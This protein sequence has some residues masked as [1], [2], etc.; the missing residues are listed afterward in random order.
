VGWIVLGT[1]LLAGV[2]IGAT[3]LPS[4]ADQDA[5]PPAQVVEN[6]QPPRRPAEQIRQAA[7]SAGAVATVIV[8]VGI[9]VLLAIAVI[10]LLGAALLFQGGLGAKG[11]G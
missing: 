10:V 1:L 2:F 7:R 5:P 11:W 9:V 4:R 6:G 8:T 3:Y